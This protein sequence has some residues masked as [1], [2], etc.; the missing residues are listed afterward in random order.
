MGFVQ[1]IHPLSFDR[2]TDVGRDDKLLFNT[3]CYCGKGETQRDETTGICSSTVNKQDAWDAWWFDLV[4][5]ACVSNLEEVL[6]ARMVAAKGKGCDGIDPDNVDS[7]C[8]PPDLDEQTD[9]FQAYNDH[10]TYGNT[11]ADQLTFN[12]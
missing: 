8:Y 4:T 3:E 11:P 1:V 5:P 2:I 10:N 12:L 9:T 7:V 6:T